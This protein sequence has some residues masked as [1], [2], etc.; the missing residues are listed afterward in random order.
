[1]DTLDPKNLLQKLDVVLDNLKCAAKLNVALG[2]VGNIVQTKKTLLERF[3]L[4][5]TTEDLK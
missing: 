3:I 5:A 2:V 1:M 4:V